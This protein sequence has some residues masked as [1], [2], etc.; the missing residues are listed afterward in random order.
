MGV[1]GVE[2]AF[3]HACK[4]E[5]ANFYAC[6]G[7]VQGSRVRVVLTHKF[8]LRKPVIAIVGYTA[9]LE[10]TSFRVHR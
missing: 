9:S 3:F 1:T 7:R 4:G 8:A 10:S 6:K 2:D 5:T